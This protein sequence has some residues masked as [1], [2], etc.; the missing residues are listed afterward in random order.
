MLLVALRVTKLAHEAHPNCRYVLLPIDLRRSHH[1]AD[2]APQI[3]AFLGEA[4]TER[5]SEAQR[6]WWERHCDELRSGGVD[7]DRFAS[8]MSLASRFAPRQP[9]APSATALARA[10]ELVP[11]W[12]PE[13]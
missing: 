9:L 11:G 12:C 13:R 1:L 2:T 6:A 7:A 3:L 8:V 10:A 5:L 4:L